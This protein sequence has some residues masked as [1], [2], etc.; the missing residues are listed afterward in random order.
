MIAGAVKLH[1]TPADV[2]EG[3]HKRMERRVVLDEPGKETRI[4]LWEPALRTWH[5]P[6]NV[7]AEQLDHLVECVR[8]GRGKIGIVPLAV[9]L[10]ASPMHGFWIYDDDRVLVE[11]VGAELYLTDDDAVEP[12][13]R[14]FS[15]LSR[16]AV[17]GRAALELVERARRALP[18]E[19]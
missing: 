9:P 5:A 2:E 7:Q 16:S 6:P 12:Y 15:A 17:R 3:V 11:T 4:L 1:G 8:A 10:L 18:D 14:V 19:G 13:R